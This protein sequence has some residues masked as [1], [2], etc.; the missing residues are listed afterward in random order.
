MLDA[1]RVSATILYNK[2]DISTD[3][4]PF[5][6]SV[7]YTDNM[8]GQADDLEIKL[9]DRNGLWEGAWMP[10]KRASLLVTLITQGWDEPGPDL[11][12]L[13]LGHFEIDSISYNYAPAEMTIKGV[14]IPDGNKLRSVERSRS[15][16]KVRLSAI[17]KDI[18]TDA[19]LTL[20][21]TAPDD[22]ELDRAEQSEESDLVFLWKLLKDYGL[23]LKIYKDKL[24][25]F[26]EADYEKV[27]PKITLVKPGTVHVEESGMMY[28]TMIKSCSFSTK[29][30]DTYKACHVRY[31]SGKK[32]SVIEATFTD[33]SKKEGK[34]LQVNEQVKSAAEAERLARRK[35]R[36]KN[37]EE[38]TGSFEVLGNFNLLSSLTVKVKGFGSFDGNYLITSAKHNL[39]SGYTTSIDIRRC[40]NGY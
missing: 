28:I 38:T 36:E 27:P 12:K 37:K 15:W 9:E 19:D 26:D 1:R 18:A 40:L 3:I 17:C 39:G 32:G 11:K 13:D 33:P 22:P 7:D 8:E 23:A 14:S 25:V 21:Y 31:K 2:K 16:E 20:S 34:T 6:Q 29:I 10:E 4:L 5:L 30:R 24:V 35:L